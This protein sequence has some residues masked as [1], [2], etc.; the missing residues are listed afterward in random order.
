MVFATEEPVRKTP[1]TMRDAMMCFSV[2]EVTRKMR[3]ERGVRGCVREIFPLRSVGGFV[4][5]RKGGQKDFS[6]IRIY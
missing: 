6:V 3:S 1:C 2:N 4:I 5:Y